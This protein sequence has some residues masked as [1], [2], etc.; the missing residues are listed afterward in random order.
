MNHFWQWISYLLPGIVLAIINFFLVEDQRNWKV[1]LKN[2]VVY[3]LAYNVIILGMN[4][5]YWHKPDIFDTNL[6]HPMYAITYMTNSLIVGLIILFIKGLIHKKLKA[7]HV[8]V[9]Y[10]STKEKIIMR[11]LKTLAVIFIG[12]E[13]FF[14]HF[15]DWFANNF[16]NLTPDQVFFNM[17]APLTGT[18]GGMVKNILLD[19]VF[20]VVLNVLIAI[21]VI[22]ISCDVYLI[23]KNRS[24]KI[25]S[26][27]VYDKVLVVLSVICMVWGV[28]YGYNKLG[29]KELIP[30]YVGNSTYFE[31]N[32]V[33]PRDITLKFPE[34]KRNLIHIYAE[35]MET[36]YLSQDFGG[37]GDVNFIPELTTLAQEDNAY[38]FSNSNVIGGPYQT[39]GASYSVAGMVNMMFGMPLKNAGFSGEAYG[40]KHFLPGGIAIGDI[41][42]AAGYNQE[43]MFG[44]DIKFGGLNHY[45]KEHGNYKQFD[46]QYARKNGYI[47][48]DYMVYWGFED[49][50][51]FEFA[52]EE[53]TKLY[54]TGK[55]F[56]FTCETANT[57]FPDG[58]LE[59]G[60]EAPYDQPY[61]NAIALSDKQIA[62][63]VRWIQEQPF[64][65][66]TTIVITGDH[67]SMDT[68]FFEGWDPNYRRAIYNV[69]INPA[70][71]T[72]EEN[73]HY[74]E[75]A[76]FD[77]YPTILASLGVDIPGDRLGLGTNLFSDKKTIIERDGVDKFNQEINFRSQYFNDHMLKGNSNLNKDNIKT[78]KE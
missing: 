75:Y 3:G 31:D 67:L 39:Y 9:E 30:A 17:M 40:Q 13:A 8:K 1:A 63:F 72:S 37:Y 5:F 48:K 49:S 18:E 19:P 14:R 10:V 28:S 58:Y 73:Q 42:E 32:Y 33:N 27:K 61:A 35:S 15:A 12:I 54:E 76:P 64:Y 43:I 25:I 4:R 36:S 22:N 69:I 70:C 34:Q 66:N 68:K 71:S 38:N 45:F 56:N 74:R 29:F 52:K 24:Y 50:K 2:F 55:P 77:F 23:L 41:L 21:F 65:D 6:F 7:D 26:K 53:I 59:P 44:S 11:T 78:R 47:P 16:G 62:E 57:H 60:A 46:L 51:L 20:A